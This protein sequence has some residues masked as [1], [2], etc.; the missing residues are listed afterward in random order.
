MG[1]KK[2]EAIKTMTAR[3]NDGCG[4]GI[5]NDDNDNNIGGNKDGSGGSK[6]C[7]G[8][9][10]IKVDKKNKRGGRRYTNMQ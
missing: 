1:V 2:T 10:C 6:K 5:N 7:D 3:N 4:G 8:Q 9:I